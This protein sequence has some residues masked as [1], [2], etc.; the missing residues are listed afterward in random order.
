MCKDR[1]EILLYFKKKIISL[2]LNQPHFGT[3]WLAD[4]E[5]RFTSTT[6]E[7][8]KASL[9]NPFSKVQIYVKLCLKNIF[10]KFFYW[11]S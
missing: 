8:G 11:E 1:G 9:R 4:F 6:E 5:K 2:K 3:D 7:G 10:R